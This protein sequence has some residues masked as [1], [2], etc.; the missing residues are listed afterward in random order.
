MRHYIGIC[1]TAVGRK[2]NSIRRLSF[3]EANIRLMGGD[4][5]YADASHRR[6]C[7]TFFKSRAQINDLH[8]RAP[9]H[10][11]NRTWFRSALSFCFLLHG[12]RATRIR[13]A[14]SLSIVGCNPLPSFTLGDASFLGS[15]NCS[16]LILLFNGLKSLVAVS[17]IAVG[18]VMA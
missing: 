17:Q 16:F 12:F 6:L 8:L 14:R 7:R 3:R 15:H 4:R 1:L 9:W 10:F 13:L 5:D 18:D 2:L 11:A